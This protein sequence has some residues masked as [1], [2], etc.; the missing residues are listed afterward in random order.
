MRRVPDS[1]RRCGIWVLF[2]ALL[3]VPGCKRE[4]AYVAPPPAHVGIAHPVSREVTPALAATGS[5]AAYNQVDLVARVQGFI[6]AIDYKDGAPAT[7][8]QTLF[9]IEPAPYQAKLQQAQA[10]LEAA[11][12]QLTQAAA[13]YTRQSSLGRNDFAARSVVD[14][15]RATR[16][17]DQA[18][19]TNQQGGVA[20]AGI[21]LGYTRV[22]APFDGTVT[23]HLVSVGDLVG[24]TSPT[25]LA[26]IVQLDPIYVNFN[27]SE[28]DVLRFKASLAKRGMTPAQL[29]KVALQVGLMNEEGYPHS[30]TIDYAAPQVDA[31]TGT[32]TVRGVFENPKRALLPGMFVRVRLPLEYQAAQALLVPDQALGTD[33]AGRYVLVVNKDNV[34]E[35]RKVETGQLSG[36]LR[37]IEAGLKPEDEVVVTGI[38]RAIPGGKVAPEPADTKAASVGSPGRKS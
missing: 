25:K 6:Q 24:V 11:Q 8:G 14:Q 35:Q 37:V 32:L 30:G 33:Q 27:V 22:T 36:D 31:S 29:G 9:V 17:A 19:V 38:Q 21:N 10:T 34:I 1:A 18:N 13:E 3:A 20:I 5:T 26:S 2:A 28:Q 23:A 15:A 16:D 7:R 12:A 4:N